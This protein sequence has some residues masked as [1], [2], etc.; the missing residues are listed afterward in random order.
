MLGY[1]V[2]V[3]ELLKFSFTHL[4]APRDGLENFDRICTLLVL[5]M[6]RIQPRRN[7]QDDNDEPISQDGKEEEHAR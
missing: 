1:R 7:G 3:T 2:S 4:E 6:A 5:A